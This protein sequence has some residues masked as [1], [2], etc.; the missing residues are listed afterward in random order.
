MPKIYFKTVLILIIINALLTALLGFVSQ[1]GLA[2]ILSLIV[3]YSIII[4]LIF[5]SY[6]FLQIPRIRISKVLS[7]IFTFIPSLVM[8]ILLTRNLI[9]LNF[10]NYRE[11]AWGIDMGR[12]F[13]PSHLQM[14][15]TG[16]IIITNYIRFRKNIK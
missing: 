6:L 2:L 15:L 9:Q 1:W 5:T 10:C 4:A 11:L 13:K 7:A 3:N 12:I 16:L 14:I 8:I